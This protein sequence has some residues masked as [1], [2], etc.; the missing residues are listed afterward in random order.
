MVEDI[1]V[2]GGGPAGAACA[3]W[4]HQLA[5]RVRLLEAGPVI[6]GLQLKSPYT[7]RWI[8]GLQGKT[9]QE[10]AASLQAHLD[11]AAVPYETGFNVASIKRCAERTC[12]EV[13]S[14]LRTHRARQVVIATGSKPRRHGFT[15]SD[16]VGIGP[17][18]SMERIEVVGKRVA[19]L[20]GGDNAF[21]QAVFALRRGARSVDIHCRRAPR[22]QPILQH[23]VPADRVHIG[24]FLADQS[25]M[26]VNDVPYD[27][28]GIQFGF[29]ASIPGGLEL[30]LR[31]G[32]IEVDRHGAIPG[33]TSLFAAGEVTN[34]WHP[35]VTTS[36]AHGVQV[37]K[38]IQA[39]IMATASSDVDARSP[40]AL[41]AAP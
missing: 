26:T 6:G 39:R 10:V 33:F 40:F 13:S 5:M 19:I 1:V 9:G 11:A 3:L 14:G 31:D 16:T 24:P 38:S 35:C 2:I 34:Y 36:Y 41:A 29:E 20:G 15:E 25:C 23:E 17:G 22:A 30:P 12:W 4:A 18:A 28:L 21:D 27:V 37:A 32:Y 8:P 7:N